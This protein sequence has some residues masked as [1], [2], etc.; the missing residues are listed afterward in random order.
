M[1]TDLLSALCSI[2]RLQK[3]FL[4]ECADRL[5]AEYHAYFL[6]AYNDSLFLQVRFE[7]TLGAAEGEANVMTVLLALA[8]EFAS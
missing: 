5:S 6:A 7:S 3:T 2:R 1:L 8:G 4:L